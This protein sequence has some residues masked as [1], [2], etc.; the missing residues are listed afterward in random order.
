MNEKKNGFFIELI[1]DKR[2]FNLES[3]YENIRLKKKTLESLKKQRSLIC[4]ELGDNCIVDVKF[5]DACIK[6]IEEDIEHLMNVFKGRI[7]KDKSELVS[8]QIDVIHAFE[9]VWHL[10]ERNDIKDVILI[11][12][13]IRSIENVHFDDDWL[14]E[15]LQFIKEMEEK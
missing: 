2:I 9:Y 8:I 13:I 1:E 5:Y 12:T 7:K 14:K 15:R 11:K 6:E 3:A 4:E 10:I